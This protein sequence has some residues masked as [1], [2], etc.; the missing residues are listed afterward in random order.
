M[1]GGRFAGPD[2]IRL[3]PLPDGQLSDYQLFSGQFQAAKRPP[4]RVQG[5]GYYPLPL[6][7]KRISDSAKD[8]QTALRCYA[9]I[10]RLRF[11][12]NARVFWPREVSLTLGHL[13]S[14]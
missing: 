3:L 6:K 8:E 4:M 11:P 7:N 5:G 2:L 14:G 10:K 1:V 12:G 9:W 13:P